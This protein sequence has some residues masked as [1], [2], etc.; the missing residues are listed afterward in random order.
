MLAEVYTEYEWLPWKFH[1]IPKWFWDDANNLRKF[2]EWAGK[3]LKI[4]DPSDWKHV[5]REVKNTSLFLAYS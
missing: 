5:K 1:I 4:K 2:L 3:E